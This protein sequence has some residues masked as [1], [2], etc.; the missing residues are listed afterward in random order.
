MGLWHFQTGHSGQ[1]DPEGAQDAGAEPSTDQAQTD[2]KLRHVPESQ[3]KHYS[4]LL[5]L[6]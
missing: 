5:L 6:L 3:V 1:R 4:I 2:P